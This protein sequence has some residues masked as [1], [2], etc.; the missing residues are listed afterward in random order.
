[1]IL[2]TALLRHRQRMGGI[3][4]QKRQEREAPLLPCILLFFYQALYSSSADLICIR[5]SQPISLR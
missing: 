2:V 1:M 4:I 5:F 3:G